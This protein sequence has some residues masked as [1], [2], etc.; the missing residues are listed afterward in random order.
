MPRS[1]GPK[2]K[3]EDSSVGVVPLD[4]LHDGGGV[5]DLAISQDKN[6][7]KVSG[8]DGL[9]EN[10]LK[11]FVNFRPAIA[12]VHGLGVFL[13]PGQ[14]VVVILHATFKQRVVAGAETE[15]T[16]K[17]IGTESIYPI[18][19]LKN[20]KFNRTRCILREVITGLHDQY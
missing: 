15:E 16:I 11:R 20:S 1:A 12:G 13:G 4:Q 6:L 19:D 17:E 14:G 10:D 9:L 18:L 5:A 2:T 3:G 8:L 7:A